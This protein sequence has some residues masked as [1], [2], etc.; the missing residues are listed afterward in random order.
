MPRII[1][2]RAPKSRPVQEDEVKSA[3][4]QAVEK[5]RARQKQVMIGLGTV[6][7]VLAVFI[8]YLLYSSSLSKKAKVFETQ[9]YN[10][11]YEMT[12]DKTLSAEDRWKKAVELYRKSIEIKASPTALY[13][14]GN[15]YYNLGDHENA[16]KQYNAFVKKFGRTKG[17]LPL[18][19]QKLA[20][21]YFRTGKNDK[22]LETL[23]KLASVE[24]G[25]FGDSALIIEARHLEGA[26]QAEKAIE[27]YRE[28]S[29][30]FPTSP[31]SAEA[32]AKVAAE[33]AKKADAAKKETPEKADARKTKKEPAAR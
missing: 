13:Y 20:S 3:A 12:G 6:A 29:M 10:Y 18:V 17:I 25:I 27:K 7:V 30:R 4:L 23:A 28:L 8:I 24:K 1:K 32:G 21:A 31:W 26:G 5:V 14:L 2:K 11:Y 22:A 33:E 9:A 16:I 15:S 19:Y